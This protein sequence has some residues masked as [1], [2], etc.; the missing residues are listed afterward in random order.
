MLQ[1]YVDALITSAGVS[2][3]H[4]LITPA[5]FDF[6]A[7]VPGTYALALGEDLDFVWYNDE[8]ARYFER[9]FGSRTIR[10]FRETM[11]QRAIDERVA[12]WRKIAAGEVCNEYCQLF[13]G[14]RRLTRVWSLDPVACGKPGWFVICSPEITRNPERTVL[15]FVHTSDLGDLKV[16]STRELVALRLIAEGLNAQECAEVEH[17]SAKT[18][19]NQV[20]SIYDKLSL[21]NRS[22]LVRFACERGLLAFS[23]EEWGKLV[24][25]A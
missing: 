6:F 18:I 21:G 13:D 12:Y 25:A 16:L 10:S 11:S 19:E 15:P 23:R 14:S 5:D 20:A 17:R 22:E 4:R 2:N 7:N 3:P 8:Y 24:G 1:N 9:R